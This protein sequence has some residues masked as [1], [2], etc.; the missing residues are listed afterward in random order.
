MTDFVFILYVLAIA[1]AYLVSK[2]QPRANK[3]AF[4]EQ[5]IVAFGGVNVCL[6]LHFSLGLAN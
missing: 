2:R 3:Y 5:C 1:D 4:E 6:D